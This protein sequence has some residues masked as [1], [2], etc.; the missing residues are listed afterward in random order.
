VHVGGGVAAFRGGLLDHVTLQAAQDLMKLLHYGDA[1]MMQIRPVGGAVH[2][3]D[4]QATAYAHRTQNFAVNAVGVSVDRLNH[5]WDADMS[6]HLNGLYISFDSDQRPERLHDAY[7]G[8]T[9]VRLCRLKALYDPN[10]IFNQSFSIPPATDSSTH[11][12]AL[13]KT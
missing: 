2:D 1:P 10:N 4:P 5:R 13:L 3:V 7:P 6:Q 8:E 9:L 11:E 12:A